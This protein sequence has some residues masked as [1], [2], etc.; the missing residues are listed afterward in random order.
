MIILSIIK[1]LINNLKNEKN[2]YIQ[3]HNFP[4]HDAI[5]S[6]YG[7]QQLLKNFGIEAFIMYKGDIQRDS[8][9]KMI[10]KLNIKAYNYTE[11]QLKD[12]NKNI[13]IDGCV[14]NKNVDSLIGEEI[15]VIDHH[16]VNASESIKYIDIRPYLGSCSTLIYTYYNE[17]NIEIPQNTASALLIGLNMDT[18]LLTRGVSQFDIEAFADLYTK[19]NISL[20]NTILRNYIQI[21][22]L[23]FYKYLLNNII[24][25]DNFAF[26]FFKDGCSQNLLGIL[27]DFL[28]ALKEIDFS[29]LCA[30]NNNI[31]NIS[32][33]NESEQLNAAEI[34]Q[35]ALNGIGFGGGHS[36]MAGGII[37][38]ISK[39]DKDII[40]NKFYEYIVNQNK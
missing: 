11:L 32:I 34:I 23:T 13:V 28:I 20:V 37:K 21:N 22:D 1:N 40:I 29:V 10:E 30:K 36:D 6:A 3:T 26:C 15:C 38:D 2:I 14:K 18:A 33:R 27:G 12:S 16:E 24:I 31:I 39:F 35:K 4:D 5:A 9:N 8:L 7:L 19:A 25:K 17:L